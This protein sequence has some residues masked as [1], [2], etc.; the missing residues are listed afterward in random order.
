MNPYPILS[1]PLPTIKRHYAIHHT[2]EDNHAKFALNY[3][4][5]HHQEEITVQDPTLQ[6][7]T[8]YVLPQL[9][10]L[11]ILESA[12]HVIN[13]VQNVVDLLII[14]IAFP[15]QQDT[16]EI[17]EFVKNVPMI[18]KLVQAKLISVVLVHYKAIY[19]F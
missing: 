6:T 17:Q 18:A 11:R 3:V 14:L 10:F 16:S 5:F 4:P 8:K 15:V 1:A 19:L 9:P 2:L 7:A 13:P 12:C